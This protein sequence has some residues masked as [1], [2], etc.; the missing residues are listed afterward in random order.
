MLFHHFDSIEKAVKMLGHFNESVN[1]IQQNSS[2]YTVFAQNYEGK[3]PQ[4]PLSN[5]SIENLDVS[6]KTSDRMN[7]IVRK[8]QCN[9]E[10][11][12]IYEQRKTNQILVAGFTNLAQA[13]DKMTSQIKSAINELNSSVGS[14]H[15]TLDN[16]MNTINSKL[17]DMEESEK[18]RHNATTKVESERATTEK[19]VMD[20]LEE[21]QRHQRYY[22][23]NSF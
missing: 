4:F 9:Y 13:L 16:S 23:R 22:K 3:P 18:Q 11:A 8:A 17:D 14:M 5:K 15:S 19:R 1:E 6:T 20:T 10:F 21:M 7:N 12:S 2:R